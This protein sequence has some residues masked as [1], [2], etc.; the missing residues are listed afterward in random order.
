[1]R[2]SCT[3]PRAVPDPIEGSLELS[4][5]VRERLPVLLLAV[6]L[7]GLFIGGWLVL[8]AGG[9][10]AAGADLLASGD[11]VFAGQIFLLSLPLWLAVLAL[12]LLARAASFFRGFGSG[13]LA[14]ERAAEAQPDEGD[15]GPRVEG[16]K[17]GGGTEGVRWDGDP[18][19]AAGGPFSALMLLAREPS[20]RAG[21]MASVFRLM[22]A[23][24]V[25]LLFIL[26]ADAALLGAGET[27]L[28]RSPPEG[29]ALMDAMLMLVGLG[30]LAAIALSSP[31]LEWT[32]LRMATIEACERA[33]P[34]RIP[35]GR[36]PLERYVRFLLLGGRGRPGLEEAL[37][38]GTV[39]GTAAGASGAAHSFDLYALMPAD[40]AFERPR[41]LF[42][43][44]LDR[45]PVLAD[46]DDLEGAVRDV[47]SAAAAPPA[48]IVMIYAP[49]DS[50]PFSER[51]EDAVFERLMGRHLS[52]RAGGLAYCCAVE[53]VTEEPDGTYDLVP[54]KPPGV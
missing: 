27:L 10:L 17:G 25:P 46:I 21:M 11:P 41:S 32:A 7:A 15:K 23:L 5:T 39:G 16:W 28:W 31:L 36:T 20:A 8:L 4:R 3:D 9:M 51:V 42:V 19:E 45:P 54:F 33:G 26:A 12:G 13:N 50:G 47:A 34:A 14:L 37:R 6:L 40:R 44:V 38:T 24:F 30:A 48:R 53:L 1:M 2:P 18:R 22:G 43:R 49:D 52:G 29:G 35:P